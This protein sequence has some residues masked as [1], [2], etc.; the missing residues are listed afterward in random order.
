[1]VW[2]RSLPAVLKLGRLHMIV[3]GFLLFSLGA[4]VA[5]YDSAPFGMGR[6]LLGFLI[7]MPA[8]LSLH[9]SND[10][11]DAEA[12]RF[13]EPTMFTGGSG[14]LVS[15]PQL[16][17][18]ARWLALALMLCSM[19]VSVIFVLAFAFP[20]WLLGYALLGNL[21]G[22]F[23]AAPPIRLSY[24]GLG[25]ISTTLTVGLLMP[26]LGYLTTRGGVADSFWLLTIPML[27]YGVAFILS[28]QIPDM[29]ADRQG[30]KRTL[31]TRIGRR[32]GFVGAGAA[33]MA[34]TVS[35]LLVTLVVGGQGPAWLPTLTLFSLVPSAI[36]LVGLVRRPEERQ[37][38]IGLV[39]AMLTGLIAFVVLSDGYLIYLLSR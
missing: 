4:L 5:L 37:A 29:E 26:G 25:E 31:V 18:V 19:M 22:W 35:L 24:R 6:F 9:Y 39:N 17:P 14:V 10:Y 32:A 7:L 27:C 33:Y 11:W 2:T 16:R 12:D 13:G 21:L 3:A 1:M 15:S 30:G 38:A 36:G 23:Y 8:H 34:A 20:A 28:V